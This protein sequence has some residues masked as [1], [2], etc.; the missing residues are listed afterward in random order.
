VRSGFRDGPCKRYLQVG[1]WYASDAVRTSRE[2]RGLY[3]KLS[4]YP[5]RYSVI[6]LFHFF[7]SISW[8]R[9]SKQ[10][11][12]PLCDSHLTIP[13]LHPNPIAQQPPL[14]LPLHFSEKHTHPLPT[15][16]SDNHRHPLTPALYQPNHEPPNPFPVTRKIRP[17][18]S[19]QLP[20]QSGPQYMEESSKTSGLSALVDVMNRSEP[21]EGRSLNLGL[22]DLSGC[23]VNHFFALGKRWSTT[24][25]DF[26]PDMH[27]CVHE[28]A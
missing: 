19:S 20:L 25:Q 28:H 24:G 5:T 26:G 13:S 17:K 11:S 1:T 8:R 3:G 2:S 18:T 12:C 4:G 21:A 27:A 9:T 23:H 10:T 22:E 16:S 15:S 6:L 7:R 14:F